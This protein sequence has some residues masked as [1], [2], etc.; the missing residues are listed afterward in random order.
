MKGPSPGLD[1]T[2]PPARRRSYF[3]EVPW[4]WRDVLIVLSPLIVI[5]AIFVLVGPRPP[6]QIPRWLPLA[7]YVLAIA[8]YT[9]MLSYPLR[10]ATRRQ[11]RWP[12]LPRFRVI[13]VETLFALLVLPVVLVTNSFVFPVFDRLLS[14][15]GEPNNPVE[16][17]AR[18]SNS[19]DWPFVIVMVIVAAP[20][21]EEVFFRGSLYNALRQRLPVILAIPIQGVIFGFL[22][23]FDAA[24]SATVAVIGIILGLLYEWR[25]TLLAPMILHVLVNAVVIIGTLASFA[26]EANAP[27]IG[28]IGKAHERGCLVTSVVPGSGADEAGIGA[29]DIIARADGNPVADLPGLARVARAKQVGDRVTIEFMRDNE[30]RTVDVVLKRRGR[31]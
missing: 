27:V 8:S 26:A 11:G 30:S 1:A 14:G 4:R 20:I 3:R 5:R 2:P 21:A 12:K 22:H 28:V 31:L 23:L 9:W 19:L 15:S 13:G 6:E 24:S 25:K 17:A 10:I 7:M 16:G 18:S 29:G